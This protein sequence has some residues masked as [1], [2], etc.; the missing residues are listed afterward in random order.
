MTDRVQLA[1]GVRRETAPLRTGW[2]HPFDAELPVY[3]CGKLQVELTRDERRPLRQRRLVEA[4]HRRPIEGRR[5][6]DVEHAEGAEF[7]HQALGL[8][9]GPFQGP[10][11]ARH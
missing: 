4:I 5:A 7:R 8:P 6:D 9:L 2:L 1:S 3:A 10:R 11:E